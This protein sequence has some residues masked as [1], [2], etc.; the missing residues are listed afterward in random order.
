MLPTTVGSTHRRLPRRRRG[1]ARLDRARLAL[2]RVRAGPRHRHLPARRRPRDVARRAV[3]ALP[4]RVRRHRRSSPPPPCGSPPARDWVA[5]LASFPAGRPTPSQ[6]GLALLHL[7]PPPRLVSLDEP[8]LVA[9]LP[10]RR[11][12][13]RRTGTACAPW[14]TP[15]RSDAVARRSSPGTAARSRR[16]A[17]DGVGYLSTLSFNHVTLRARRA[18]PGPVPPAGLRRGAGR[19]TPRRCAPRCP[20]RCCT[21]TACACHLDPAD[22]RP[23]PR[24]RR[25]AAV[26]SSATRQRCTPGIDRLRELGVHVVDPHTWLLGGP[27]LA[28]IR[29][30]AARQR[31]RRACSTRGRFRS[32]APSYRSMMP[33]ASRWLARAASAERRRDFAVPSGMLSSRATSRYVRPC[34]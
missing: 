10:G 16:C 21:S 7:D 1:R 30:A 4:A 23:R 8:G 22:P 25:A 20:A 26:A 2:G 32:A 17:A 3:P 14:W 27:A 18:R 9:H 33:S 19:P 29:A 31:P 15:P 12:H 5:V 24:V 34:R 11:G 28:G 6:A 13:A